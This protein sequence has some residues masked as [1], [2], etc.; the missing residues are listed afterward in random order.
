LQGYGF[1]DLAGQGVD[2]F[3]STTEIVGR[4]LLLFKIKCIM[5]VL[6]VKHI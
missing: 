2:G 4:Q 5:S 1:V 6:Q 3:M